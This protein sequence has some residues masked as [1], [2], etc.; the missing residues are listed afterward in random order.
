MIEYTYRQGLPGQ[1][2]Q[3]GGSLMDIFIEKI[4]ARKK[5]GTDLLINGAIILATI[6]L[7]P[8]IFNIPVVGS[9]GILV[10]AAMV[11]GAYY[12]ITSKN[13]EYEYVVTNGDIDIDKIVSQRKRKRIFSTSCKE[14]DILARVK[15]SHY[16]RHVQDIKN[17]ITAVSSM[18]SESAYF[19]TLSYKGEKTVVFFEPD[20]R[21]LNNFRTFISRKIMTE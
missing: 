1:T 4:V 19:A 8:V 17:K 14:F 16:G 3:V 7:I 6:I 9:M 21:M 5:T 18:D 12:L 13:L 15:S 2:L 10:V 11:Y 20:E